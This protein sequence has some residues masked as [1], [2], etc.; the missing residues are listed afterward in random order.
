MWQVHIILYEYWISLKETKG[1]AWENILIL[2]SLHQPVENWPIL[3]N[4]G[5]KKS[6]Q[7]R[8]KGPRVDGPYAPH[9]Q[10][11]QQTAVKMGCGWVVA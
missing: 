8:T 3:E 7:Q 11:D 9:Q 1:S 10:N 4:I 2:P 6:Q 5:I